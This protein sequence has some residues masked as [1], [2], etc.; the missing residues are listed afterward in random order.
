MPLSLQLTHYTSGPIFGGL[1]VFVYDWFTKN[2]FNNKEKLYDSAI[3]F[4]SL[5]STNVLKNSVVDN[6]FPSNS[7]DSIQNIMFKL[8]S[9]VVIYSYLYSYIMA[10]LDSASVMGLSPQIEIGLIGAIVYLLTHYF[11]NPLVSLITNSF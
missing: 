9:N 8:V 11:N 3:M 5:L 4:A 7:E 2:N 10:N 6:I 1:I